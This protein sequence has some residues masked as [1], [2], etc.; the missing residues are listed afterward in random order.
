MQTNP[1]QQQDQLLL[2]GDNTGERNGRHFG[3]MNGLVTLIVVMIS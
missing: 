1:Q 3:V 2:L